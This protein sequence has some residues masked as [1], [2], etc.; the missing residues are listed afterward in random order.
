MLLPTGIF[1]TGYVVEDVEESMREVEA[2]FDVAWSTVERRRLALRGPEGPFE[3]D[4]TFVYTQQG[5]PH[6]E[7][8]AAVPGTPWQV[9]NA[10]A[11]VGQ[12]A[13]HHVGIWSPDLVAD[14]AA[15]EAAGAPLVVTY[16]GRGDGV[17]GFA[18]HRL[19]SGMLVELVDESRRPDFETWFAGGPFP[20]AGRD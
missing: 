19:P 18:Y 9:A 3:A 15:L 5:P 20:S 6:I 7:L 11:P 12:Q 2:V 10:A 13:A 1:H 16:D 14:S 17:R 8:L 4:M